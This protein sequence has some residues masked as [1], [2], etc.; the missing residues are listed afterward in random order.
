MDH[1]A[2]LG[3]SS[4]WGYKWVPSL[5]SGQAGSLVVSMLLVSSGVGEDGR[6]SALGAQEGLQPREKRTPGRALINDRPG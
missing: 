4:A 6:G 1:S 5:P 2:W 3:K